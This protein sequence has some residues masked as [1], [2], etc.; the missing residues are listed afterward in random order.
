[1]ILETQ[2]RVPHRGPCME[3]ASP[4]ACVSAQNLGLDEKTFWARAEVCGGQGWAEQ[5]ESGGG[6]PAKAQILFCCL[7]IHCMDSEE[8]FNFLKP[9]C[10]NLDL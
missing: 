2:D 9:E 4:S 8:P 10:I 5:M 3:P 1:M 6:L 7:D